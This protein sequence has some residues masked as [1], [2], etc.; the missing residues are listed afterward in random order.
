MYSYEEIKKKKRYS[1]LS[2]DVMRKEKVNDYF[3]PQHDG[4]KPVDMEI[5]Q[6]QDV[7]MDND[8]MEYLR[9]AIISGLGVPSSLN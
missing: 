4:N 7:Q 3:I 5:I 1:L 8:F 9:K 6:G 2:L